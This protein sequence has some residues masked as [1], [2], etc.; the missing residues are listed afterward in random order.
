[1]DIHISYVLVFSFTTHTGEPLDVPQNGQVYLIE[2][3]ETKR[4]LFQNGDKIKGNRGDEGGWSGCQANSVVGADANYNNRAFW[5]IIPQGGGT[6]FFEN[7]ETKRYLFQVGDKIKGKHGDEGG[8]NEAPSL[9][10][11]DANYYNRAYWKILSQG[12]DKYFIEN[13]DTGRYLFQT[14]DAIE[15]DRG[16]EGWKV[17]SGFES[18]SVVGTDANYYNRAYWKLE[19]EH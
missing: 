11:T 15:G 2:N 3:A 14:G 7:I 16:T 18:P 1:M 5:K 17:S 9:L 19:K 6:Y 10:G 8:W 12:E 4:Y 13:V